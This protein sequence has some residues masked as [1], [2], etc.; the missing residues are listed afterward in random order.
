[1]ALTD[2]FPT[3]KRIGSV[4]FIV[5]LPPEPSL[6]ISSGLLP[7]NVYSSTLTSEDSGIH[8]PYIN[9]IPSNKK[10]ALKPH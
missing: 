1:M 2:T 9:H 4:N 7:S 10:R 8:V 3:G 6:F 5:L